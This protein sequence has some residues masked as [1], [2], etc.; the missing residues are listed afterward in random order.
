MRKSISLVGL[1]FCMQATSAHASFLSWLGLEDS[2]KSAGA[3]AGREAALAVVESARYLTMTTNQFGLLINDFHGSDP[4]KKEDARRI[5]EGAFGVKINSGEN[6][7][8]EVSVAYPGLKPDQSVRGDVM[9]ISEESDEQVRRILESGTFFKPELV[10]GPTAGSVDAETLRG[11]VHNKVS[12]FLKLEC[13]IAVG[14]NRDGF[15]SY[16]RA[17]LAAFNDCKDNVKPALL[18]GAIMQA[19]STIPVVPPKSTFSREYRGGKYA[20]VI[21]PSEDVK[22]LPENLDL[23]FSLHKAGEPQNRV[24]DFKGSPKKI[25]KDNLTKKTVKTDDKAAPELNYVFVNLRLD[26]IATAPGEPKR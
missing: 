20:V 11:A 24:G 22:R 25:S 5:L 2:L 12:D 16:S 9:F 26:G 19:V 3:E 1:L 10:N 15:P 8:L 13:Q 17:Q 7:S 23:Q 14:R 18:T 6:F 4:K 21:M